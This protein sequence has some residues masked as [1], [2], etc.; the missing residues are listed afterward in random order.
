MGPLTPH[1]DD[2]LTVAVVHAPVT[3]APVGGN[4]NR[5]R[6][7]LSTG[8]RVPLSRVEPEPASLRD[9]YKQLHS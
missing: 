4:E 5:I 1:R 6:C 8:H 9:A 3:I 7:V 2:D